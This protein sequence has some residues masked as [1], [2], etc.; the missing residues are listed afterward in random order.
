MRGSVTARLDGAPLRE[1][2]DY[3]LDY[4][5][6]VLFLFTIRRRAPRGF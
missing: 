5:T 6:G 3:E 1:G 4:E 2:E